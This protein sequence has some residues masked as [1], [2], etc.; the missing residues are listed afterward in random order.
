MPTADRRSRPLALAALLLVGAVTLGGCISSGSVSEYEG[1]N[2]G[3]RTLA[4]IEPGETTRAWILAVLGEP[5]E[6]STVDGAGDVEVWKWVR[7]KMT[8][9]RGSA[10][11]V[12]SKSRTEEVRTVYVEL[13]D[14][15]VTRAWRD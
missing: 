4:Q 13:T 14:G 7:R 5:T 6:R 11:V 8:T 1:P 10:L 15:V 12:S 3:D 9:T 2:I